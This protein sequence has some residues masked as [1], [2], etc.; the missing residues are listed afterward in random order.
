MIVLLV[1]P[2][3]RP[4][5]SAESPIQHVVVIFQENHTFDNLFGTYPGANGIQNDPKTAVTPYH[6]IQPIADL[7][8]STV[9]AH[10]AY[11]KGKMDGFP[12]AEGAQAFGYY[13]Q[14]DMSYY[15][16]LA[17]NY[18]LF[19]N[20]FSSAMGPSLP[21][22]LFLVAGQAAGITGSVN[23]LGNHQL[24]ISSIIDPLEA[25]H[26]S[27]GY[28]SPYY[29]GNENALGMISSVAGNTSRVAHEK[30]LGGAFLSDVKTGNLP[31]VSWIMPDDN[32]SDHPPYPLSVGQ[33]YV[34]GLVS[35]IQS[36]QYWQSTVIFLTWD[37]YGGW[38]DHVVPPQ[39]D[40][41]GDG[42]R[43]PMIMISPMAKPGVVDHTFSDHTSIMK[44]IERVF[45]LPHVATRDKA[46]SDL[47]DGLSPTAAVHLTDD[48][49]TIRGI[50]SLTT[51]SQLGQLNVTYTNTLS[52]GQT[53]VI[54][55]SVKN[56]LNQ[57]IEVASFPAAFGPG[58]SRSIPLSFYDLPQGGAY[59]VK[60][61]ST[62]TAGALLST[63]MV[64]IRDDTGVNG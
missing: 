48:S 49:L 25:R 13:D 21:N 42:F 59:Q 33:S 9:C 3:G 27:W 30:I 6:I 57:T 54:F 36:S 12:N 22:H 58:E 63:T 46:A 51:A 40:K 26:V 55:A 23:E 11:D 37:D 19:D 39:V 62:S 24:N 53:G 1:L 45:N 56:S 44:F 7:C 52:K 64:I 35:A 20:Y 50:P 47:M 17:H 2:L 31:A 34:K 28:Y 5:T 61:F 18:T 60:F 29:L 32:E 41:M 38:Y 14:S 15:W 43:V 16:S 8:H 4:A 10:Q